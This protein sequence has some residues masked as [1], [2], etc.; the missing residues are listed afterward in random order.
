MDYLGRHSSD[1]IIR[2]LDQTL[3]QNAYHPHTYLPY[4]HSESW[5][6]VRTREDMTPDVYNQEATGGAEPVQGSS[7][8]DQRYS[9]ERAQRNNSRGEK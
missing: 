9:R 5:W 4:N 1:N 6:T 2:K 3:A 8:I 7:G